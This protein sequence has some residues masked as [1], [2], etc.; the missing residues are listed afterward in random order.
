MI[1][2]AEMM[3]V[4]SNKIVVVEVEVATI[5]KSEATRTQSVN[6]LTNLNIH[7][8]TVDTVEILVSANETC[9]FNKTRVTKI[10]IMLQIK[11]F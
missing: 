3:T 9:A 7:H 2:W 11:T 5:Q 8:T 1:I 10:I 6:N 4:F